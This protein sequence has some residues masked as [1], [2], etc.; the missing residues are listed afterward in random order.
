MRRASLNFVIDAVG[1]AGFVF[2][3]TTGVLIRYVLPP[4]SGHHTTLWGLDRHDWGS[5][6]FWI[7][8]AFL[9]VV[10]LHLFYHWRWVVS[11]V[12]GRPCE[13]SGM[14][15]ALGAMA[16]AAIVA[17]AA[18]PFVAPI[19]RGPVEL[20]EQEGERSSEHDSG[21]IRG[22]MSL[23]EIEAATG[24]PP[25]YLV[26]KLELPADVSLDD[27]VGK[28]GKQHGFDVDQVRAAVNEYLEEGDQ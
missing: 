17:V 5:I 2:L 14:R 21:G 24:V 13:G 25:A 10:A 11:V 6:H 3:T 28:I 15:L 27:G 4:G 16:L 1:F 8:V 9:C 20:H 7:A 18:A 19:E 22:R 12:R 26:E 23:T